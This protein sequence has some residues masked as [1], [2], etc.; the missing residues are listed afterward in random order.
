MIDVINQRNKAEEIVVKHLENVY[1]LRIDKYL[2]L[3]KDE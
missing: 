3:A 2:D 1:V